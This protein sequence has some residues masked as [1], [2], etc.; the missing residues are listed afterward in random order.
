MQNANPPAIIQPARRE[1]PAI[2]LAPAGAPTAAPDPSLSAA[3]AAF[4]ESQANPP[5]APERAARLLTRAPAVA[6]AL[7]AFHDSPDPESTAE[8]ARRNPPGPHQWQRI[9]ALQREVDWA[10][11]ARSDLDAALNAEAARLIRRALRLAGVN[12]RR[13]AAITGEVIAA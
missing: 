3:Y 5:P 2:V 12:P 9:A 8:D 11:E 13:A 1:S 6:E 10:E 7:E 4:R